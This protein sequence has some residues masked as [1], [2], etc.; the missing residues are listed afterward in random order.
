[1]LLFS[2][3]AAALSVGSAAAP[4]RPSFRCRTPPVRANFFSSFMP[5]PPPSPAD[6]YSPDLTCQPACLPASFEDLVAGASSGV[7]AALGA[8]LSAVEVEFPP[9]AS[10]N[11]RGDGSAASERLVHEANA[12]F[13][14]RLAE[15]CGGGGR[16]VM[17]V[18]CTGGALSA[19]GA[20]AVSLRDAGRSAP[21]VH[22]YLLYLCTPLRPLRALSACTL[23]VHP[24]RAPAACTLCVHALRPLRPVHLRPVAS[25][26]AAPLPPRTLP[27]ASRRLQ[28]SSGTLSRPWA[29]QHAK[30]GYSLD[31]YGCSMGCIGLQPGAAEALCAIVG[32]TI[33]PRL[34]AAL[35]GHPPLQKPFARSGRP[36]RPVSRESPLGLEGRGGLRQRWCP[37]VALWC[38]AQ[39]ALWCPAQKALWCPA[40]KASIPPCG[41]NQVRA[42]AWSWL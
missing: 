1:M 13:A 9:V 17:L 15:A 42:G 22:L 12:A 2:A 31:A 24:L 14:A 5:K 26:L 30:Y 35:C 34:A 4:T 11:A 37:G 25:A 29:P 23:C 36:A 7:A 28:T 33:W 20:G 39:K 6:I 38:P 40:Q 8:G 10:A 41:S 18:G 32:S 16:R 27:S 21:S 19:L 3:S